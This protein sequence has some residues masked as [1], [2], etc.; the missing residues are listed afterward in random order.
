MGI[1][2][3]KTPDFW[4]VYDVELCIK[5]MRGGV[6]KDPALVEKSLIRRLKTVNADTEE[7]RHIYI[8]QLQGLGV[9]VNPEDSYEQLVKAAQQAAAVKKTNGFLS[10]EHGLYV[11]A[12]QFKAA[13]KEAAATVF[14]IEGVYWLQRPMKTKEGLT[15]GKAARSAVAEWVYVS[16]DQIYLRGADDQILKQPTGTATK[17]MHVD[18]A[19]GPR[20][21][22]GYVEFVRNVTVRFQVEV[23]KNRVTEQ[24]WW[25]LW[26]AVEKGGIGADRALGKGQNDLLRFDLTKRNTVGPQIPL[27]RP[28]HRASAGAD[29][30][31]AAD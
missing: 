6:S 19:Q 8:Q 4:A 26:N 30:Q 25:A 7:F 11:G 12:Y 15:G 23:L 16:P 20:D 5:E 27:V 14:G 21:A 1:F 10:D 29:D 31:A 22:L 2:Q 17:V 13:L 18:T 3:G 9:D 24:Q 28:P